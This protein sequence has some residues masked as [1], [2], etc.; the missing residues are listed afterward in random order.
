[1][2]KITVRRGGESIILEGERSETLLDALRRA[3][4]AVNAPCGGNG[5]CGKCR[6]RM[7]SGT[8]EAEWAL[9][10]R[11]YGE[12]DMEIL[13]SSEEQGGDICGEG[14]ESALFGGGSGYGAAVDIGTTTV[15]LQLYDLRTGAALGERRDWNAQRPY[16]ADVV[17]RMQYIMENENG[18]TCL[19]GLIRNQV[20]GMLDDLCGEAGIDPLEVHTLYVAGNTVMQH[21]FAGLDPRAIAL[22]PY[23]PEEYFDDGKPSK[24]PERPGLAV[25]YAPCVAGYVGGDITAGILSA[26]VH[27]RPGKNLF[28]DVGTNGE[29][30]LCTEEGLLCCSV[31]CGPAFEGAEISCGMYS[32][33]GAVCRVDWV[34]GKPVTEVIGG[35][36]ARGLCG[37]GILDL[38]AMLLC[39]GAVDD[40]GRLL[41]PDEAPDG[42]EAWLDED[43]DGNGVFWLTEDR[44]VYFT[45]G[46]VRKIQ[47]AKG[48]VAAGISLL[49][50]EAGIDPAE[51]NGV[52]I[53]GGFGNAMRP[54]SAAAIGMIPP[55]LK[56]RVSTRG[57]TALSGAARVLCDPESREELLAIRRSC[58][59][60][61]LAGNPAFTQAFME[62][63]MFESE[64]E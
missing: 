11:T 30:A 3:G 25:Y 48:A 16:G 21:L 9:A 45:A 17:S 28:L 22:A 61:E 43:E 62:C 14:G 59:Y 27:K 13:L 34:D 7:V 23:V 33:P 49:L 51:I 36:E 35:G 4:F 41:P 60:L 26:G 57:N 46:D 63:M 56:D 64:D 18:L 55:E 32:V 52:Y 58:R 31:A 39:L 29:M 2:A 20:F 44:N 50:K 12:R 47:L 42:L 40:T 8:G 6:V 15:V 37:S 54:A 5:K 19:T 24:L 10:C 1:M 53:A 38:L